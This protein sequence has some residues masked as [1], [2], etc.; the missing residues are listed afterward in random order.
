MM[1]QID[2]VN[3]CACLCVCACVFVYCVGG[4]GGRVRETIPT[5]LH[6]VYVHFLVILIFT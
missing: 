5:L 4:G 2:S 1:S 6:E 3:L